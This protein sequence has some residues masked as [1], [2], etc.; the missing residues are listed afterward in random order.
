MW[1][2]LSYH[3]C[4]NILL[5]SDIPLLVECLCV[6][7]SYFLFLQKKIKSNMAKNINRK[8]TIY[9]NS[10]EVENTIESVRK[11]VRCIY[12][13]LDE[14]NHIYIFTIIP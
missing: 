2:W 8:V 1:L 9:L 14:L 3:N 6:F 4:N 12:N 10:K 11:E 13:L 7:V 5:C